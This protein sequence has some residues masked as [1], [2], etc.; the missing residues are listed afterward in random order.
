MADSEVVDEWIRRA[1]EDLAFASACLK[2]KDRYFAQICF[3]FHQT[4]EK[5]LKA[6]ILAKEL[7]LEKVHDLVRLLKICSTKEPTLMDL[8]EACEF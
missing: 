5:H 2:D 6:F 1:D 3:H 7:G 8:R 4:A